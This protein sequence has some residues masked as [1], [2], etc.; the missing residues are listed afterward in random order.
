MQPNFHPLDILCT[1]FSVDFI[2]CVLHLRKSLRRND[3]TCWREERTILVRGRHSDWICCRGYRYVLHRQLHRDVWKLHSDMWRLAAKYSQYLM[4]VDLYLYARTLE[5]PFDVF[6]SLLFLE[7]NDVYVWM[8]F[9]GILGQ[10]DH[11]FPDR[12]EIFNAIESIITALTIL[13]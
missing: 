10:S 7:R 12:F 4:D 1:G 11:I 5:I 3:F 13:N 9:G 6:Y 2:G 8:F